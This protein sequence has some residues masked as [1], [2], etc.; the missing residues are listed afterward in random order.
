MKKG[1]VFVL[2][3][4]LAILAGFLLTVLV[5]TPKIENVSYT[6]MVQIIEDG[7]VEEVTFRNG[8]IVA[9]P[10]MEHL[11][12]GADIE[13]GHQWKT[14]QGGDISH[15]QE[16]LDEQEIKYAFTDEEAKS[17]SL[18]TASFVM[19]IIFYGILAIAAVLGVLVLVPLVKRSLEES[20]NDDGEG[21]SS[22]FSRFG[23]VGREVDDSKITMKDVAGYESAKD[24][25]QEI[26]DF[27]KDP[28]RFERLGARVPKG[29]LLHGPP[30]TGKTL[31]A[32]AVAGEADVPF[33]TMSGS[34]F[35]EMY[36]GLG[37]S[38]VRRLFKKARKKAPCI[39]FIDEVDAVG[40]KRVAAASGGARESDQTLNALLTEMDGFN[41]EGAPVIIIGATNRPD[42]L[43]GALV[44]PGRFERQI[45][46]GHPNQEARQRILE[47]HAAKKVVANTVDLKAI[48]QLTVGMV[49]AD[50][51]NI[52]NEAT[53]IA[54]KRNAEA[55]EQDDFLA[56][57]E[58]VV[59]GGKERGRK[60][61]EEDR[62]LVAVHEAGHAVA[63]AATGHPKRVARISIIPSTRGS[64]GH[65]LVLP[66]DE[67]DSMIRTRKEYLMDVGGL[68]GGRA[69]EEVVLDV[70]TNGASGDLK[71]VHSLL[72]RMVSQMGLSKKFF[73]RIY[74]ESSHGYMSMYADKTRYEID[75]EVGRLTDIMYQW[76]IAV[77]QSNRP[78]IAELMAIL[79]V[80]EEISGERL[81]RILSKVKPMNGF[82]LDGD[83]TSQKTKVEESTEA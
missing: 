64:L 14:P 30:G 45:Y 24:D 61:G 34:D 62:R 43:D 50:M 20:K 55:V 6:E 53:L 13:E 25:L 44:R 54:T 59:V 36:V 35:V 80:E 5:H 56:A 26:I 28:K 72:Y 69:A 82:D 4:S 75:E 79:L 19:Q 33:I 76:T 32:K 46:M 58:K 37:A 70:V 71:Q 68:L 22:F 27:L 42:V 2:L 49:G 41:T 81:E 29:V 16:I 74:P 12:N 78:V 39:L 40:G 1:L 18:E 31:L 23:S 8:E 60:L 9:L 21:G 65:N 57:I 7:R 52:V 3:L 77:M 48:A 38:R 73:N 47:I 15:L 17:R 83:S 63:M 10:Q 11:L 67:K 51:E 66:E